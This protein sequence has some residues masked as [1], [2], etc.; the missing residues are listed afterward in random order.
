[1]STHRIPVVPITLL[2][3]PNADSLSIVRIDDC[4]VVVRTQDWEGIDRGIHVPPDYMI[5]RRFAE[6]AAKGDEERIR[7]R[8]VRLRGELSWGF[9]IPIDRDELKGPT[10]SIP[11]IGSDMINQ[12]QITRYEPPMPMVT[13]GDNVSG[14][15]RVMA[16]KYDV[17]SFERYAAQLFEEDEP[18]YVTEKIH[19]A[20]ARY[21]TV[22]GQF[23][24][25]SRANW[26]KYDP[27]S[28]WWRAVETHPE[29]RTFCDENEGEVLYGE[30]YGPVQSLR[31]GSPNTVR[32]AAFD[33]LSGGEWVDPQRRI[34]YC[35]IYG[36]PH[37]PVLDKLFPFSVE[38]VRK[39]ASGPSLIEGADHI[40]EGV[41]IEPHWPRN[42]PEVGR[43]QLKVVSPDYLMGNY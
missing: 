29:I 31:Y 34:T 37:V 7:V 13:G 25:G 40:R 17:E 6:W 32:F 27:R 21:V 30:I 8:P 19:G 38:G 26:K 4:Q 1:M 33:I 5:P 41:V 14:P 35:K 11:Q 36:V 12:M 2:P 16:P 42:H 28:V 39:L 20:N 18:V 9:L 23:Y 24:C 3:H 10:G 22:D 15:D 43:V